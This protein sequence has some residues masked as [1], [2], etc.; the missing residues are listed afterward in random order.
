MTYSLVEYNS[1]E[2]SNIEVF[3]KAL[4]DQSLVIGDIRFSVTEKQKFETSIY[5]TFFKTINYESFL[6]CATVDLTTIDISLKEI[7]QLLVDYFFETMKV[8]SVTDDILVIKNNIRDQGFCFKKNSMAF[9]GLPHVEI[10]SF[11]VF[12]EII[13]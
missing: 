3:E 13:K 2:N 8:V 1:E 7:T 5:T 9:I 4:E 11:K 6:S 12:L 10:D